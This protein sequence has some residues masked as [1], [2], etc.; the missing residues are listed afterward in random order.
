[1]PASSLNLQEYLG[2]NLIHN[3]TSVTSKDDNK[4]LGQPRTVIIVKQYLL[5]ESTR[6]FYAAR[7]YLNGCT[8]D[9]GSSLRAQ[10]LN[11]SPIKCNQVLGSWQRQNLL[12]S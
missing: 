9:V 3:V 7:I 8:C 10:R 5:H 2:I 6:C 11:K 12:I 1:M 4:L